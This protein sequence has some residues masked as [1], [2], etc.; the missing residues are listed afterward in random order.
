M[1]IESIMFFGNYPNPIDK[2]HTV[3]F[4]NLIYQ[5]ADL[6]ICCTVITP[7]SILKYRSKV[8]DIPYD[9]IEYTEAGNP[10][11]VVSPRCMSYSSKK[12]G[13]I[14]THV[15]TV[16]AFRNAAIQQAKKLGIKIDATYGHFINIG[17]IPACKV[18]K[19]FNVPSFVANGESDLNPKTYNYS[20]PYDLS[21]FKDCSGV[22]SVSQKNKEEL[23]NLRLI[24][25]NRIRVFPN[26][27]N[28]SIFYPHNKAECR[29]KYGIACEDI[30]GCFVG[31][32][33]ERKGDKRVLKASK[34]IQGLKMVFIGDGDEK[35]SGDNVLLCGKIDHNELPEL[36]SACD[37]FVLPTLNE[38]CC[39]AI[40]EALA[41]G[42]PVISSNL[43]FNNGILTETNSIRI[44]PMDIDELSLAMSKL[45]KDPKLRMKLAEGAYESS[46][47]FRIQTRAK[48]IIQFMN[49]MAD[50][51]YNEMSGQ[52]L[53]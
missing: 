7:V 30:V 46:G 5:F 49:E 25:A 38:G 24:D 39:N 36:L 20:S 50:N 15:W 12:L 42:L 18:G 10:V 41:C 3:F 48:N 32:F 47:Q 1:T 43:P 29:K 28:S 31:T 9:R 26:G 23:L 45:T 51:F 37:F 53:P 6:G 17:G 19:A 13:P 34:R 21:A 16:R 14:D 44:D 33:S 52:I 40:L 22:I 8:R 11:R 2:N 4:K 27:V 35:P